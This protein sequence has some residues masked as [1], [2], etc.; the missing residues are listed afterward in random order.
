MVTTNKKSTVD[1]Q[2]IKTEHSNMKITNFQKQAETEKNNGNS[3][4]PDTIKKMS[5]ESSHISIITLNENGL[6]SVI[7]R[8]K[9]AGWIKSHLYA[10]YKRH[11]F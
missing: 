4:Q 3:K 9:V 7:K 11:Q 1:A 5:L 6:N 2:R 8:S 10:V